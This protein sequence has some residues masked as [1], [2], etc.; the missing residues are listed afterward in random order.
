[1]EHINNNFNKEKKKIQKKRLTSALLILLIFFLGILTER[2]AFKDKI[3]SFGD[4]VITALSNKIFIFYTNK[5]KLIINIKNKNYKKILKNR[6]E[7]LKMYRASEDMHIWVPANINF[8]DKDYKVKI[9][10][11]GVHKEHW[12][13]PNKWSFKIK[14]LDGKAINGIKRFSIQQPHTRN[15]LNEWFFMEVL[16]KEGLI[17][18]RNKYVE[19]TVNGNN[20]G[21][22]YLEEMNTKQLIENSKRREGPIIGIDKDLW[23]KEANNMKKLG[24]NVLEDSFWRAK[25]KPVQFKKSLVGTEQ[26]IYLKEAISLFENFRN[27][28]LKIEEVFDLKQLAKLMSIKAI[29]GSVEF[30]W[31]DIKFYYNPITSLL[32]PIGREVHTSEIF[33]N[34]SVWWINDGYLKSLRSE[35]NQFLNLIIKHRSFYKMFLSELYRMTDE[36]YLKDILISNNGSFKKYK[37]ILQINSPTKE[38]FSMDYFEKIRNYIR[39]TLNPIQGI[40]AYFIN[41]KK[42][43]ILL[44]IQN[45]QALPVE[46]K[47]IK[48]NKKNS[49]INLDKLKTINGKKHNQ[50][51]ENFILKIPCKNKSLCSNVNID[52]IEVVYNILGQKNDRFA[53]LSKFYKIN[54]FDLKSKNNEDE[55][56]NLSFIS[57]D[58]ENKIINFANGRLKID[59]EIIIPEDYIVNFQAGSEITFSNKG[60]ILSYSAIKINGTANNPI[61]FK[62]DQI[63]DIDNHGYG[64]SV[65]NANKVSKIEYAI[66]KD[67]SHPKI[68][69]GYGFTGS[70]N[71][72]NSNIKIE[73]SKFINNLYGDDYLN[74]ISSNFEIRNVNFMNSKHD[75]IDFD[76]SNGT[77]ENL[78]ISNTGNDALDFS[79]SKVE[80]K[81]ILINSVGD[82]GIS[83][84]EKSEINVKNLKIEN[85]NIAVASKDLSN[86]KIENFKVNNSKVVAA[87]YQKKKEYGPAQISATNV[88]IR[89]NEENYLS[90]LKSKIIID[91]E[92]VAHKK[93]DY[94]VF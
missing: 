87:A 59:R 92:T 37:R 49:R 50:S 45:T 78:F 85:A 73:N 19:A 57:I 84:G 81:D 71:F 75:A 35:Q 11:K 67:L 48:L 15:Y 53:S 60:L 34:N 17:F 29:F 26:E 16:K 86:L 27:G 4:G 55:L 38:I 54:N 32:E 10:L 41:Y 65:V 91:N 68:I 94:S 56:S 61:I 42:D 80:L 63:N 66:F 5:E 72:F 82:K 39:N 33:N 83:A 46:I 89:N 47:G 21:I 3:I 12:S 51:L 30:D 8:N 58:K 77:I 69:K 18:H 31:R 70:V 64:I 43:E 76:Y 40:N 6:N 13:H 14:L 22:Y 88:L 25:I 74:I 36:N 7:S 24:I 52:Q 9:K 44:S 1:M 2:F 90:Q 28:N 23:I 62:S 79:G 93:L 20:L